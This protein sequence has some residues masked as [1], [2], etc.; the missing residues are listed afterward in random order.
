MHQFQASHRLLF[1]QLVKAA[2]TLQFRKSFIGMAWLFLSPLFG[3]VSW[4]FLNAAGVLD[5]GALTVPYPVYLLIGMAVWS[6]FVAIYNRCGN[7]LNNNAKLLLSADL[8][9]SLFIAKE[10]VV[11]LIDFGIILFFNIVVV[12]LFGVKLSWAAL[13]F[14]I[15]LIP[16][17]I[18]GMAIGL[19]IALCKVVAVDVARLMDQVV[20]FLMFLTPIVYSDKIKITWLKGIIPYNPL[21]YL[22]GVPRDILLEGKLQ[23]GSAFWLST[24]FSAVFLFFSYR[25]FA[26]V[27]RKTL[28]RIINN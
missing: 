20:K 16:L 7:V 1:R 11:Y 17:I 21:T 9:L 15:L 28:E 6:L 23:L 14:P 8:P 2:V 19:L 25:L 4:L 3:V 18:L 22:V 10:V 13:L 12:L 24:L 5:P 27:A 26:S